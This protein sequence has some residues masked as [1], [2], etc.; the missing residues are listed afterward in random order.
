LEV[1]TSTRSDREIIRV[2]GIDQL[3]PPM[4]GTLVLLH[5]RLERAD[6]GSLSVDT[7]VS[8]LIALGV[9]TFLLHAGLAALGCENP[10]GSDWNRTCFALEGMT[11]YSVGPGFPAITRDRFVE[12]I[13]R[14]LSN[15]IYDV[16]LDL[17]SAHALNETAT[18]HEIRRFLS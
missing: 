6:S 8:E 17:A 12:G 14:G 9:D 3:S 18:E 13:P 4:G 11:A 15:V 7:L 5:I 16:N 2:H 1:K 10:A